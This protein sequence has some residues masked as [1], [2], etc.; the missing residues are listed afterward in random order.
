M[1]ATS[2]GGSS[3]AGEGREVLDV[4]R[5]RVCEPEVDTTR[6]VQA[7]LAV[8]PSAR[9]TSD[10]VECAVDSDSGRSGHSASDHSAWRTPLRWKAR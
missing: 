5:D 6:E 8:R 10:E 1:A 3:A 4:G 7:A 2:S 9:R